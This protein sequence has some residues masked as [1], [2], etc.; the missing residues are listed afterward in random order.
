MEGRKRKLIDIK[1]STFRV[2][3]IQATL[4]GANLKSFIEKELDKL[5]ESIVY[6]QAYRSLLTSEPDG[7]VLLSKKEKGDFE[8]DLSNC[9]GSGGKFTTK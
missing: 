6:N 2:L 8:R 9:A 4:N 1:E 5:V 3:S 7:Q